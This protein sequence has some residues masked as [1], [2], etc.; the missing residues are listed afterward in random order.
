MG[1][2][3]KVIEGIVK[4]NPVIKLNPIQFDRLIA[5]EKNQHTV[6]GKLVK[7]IKSRSTVDFKCGKKK[8]SQK[9]LGTELVLIHARENNSPLVQISK[10][11]EYRTLNKISVQSFALR[12]GFNGIGNLLND[13]KLAPGQKSNCKILHLSTVRYI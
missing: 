12:E 10:G 6:R 11:S 13:M 7:D 3:K 9:V 2:A 8:L 5:G 1:R 4:K